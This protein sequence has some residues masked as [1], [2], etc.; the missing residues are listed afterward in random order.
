LTPLASMRVMAERKGIFERG[1]LCFEIDVHKVG[2]REAS[3]VQQVGE[4]LFVDAAFERLLVTVA[5]G[6]VFLKTLPCGSVETM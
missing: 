1:S 6:R 5:T 3:L 4:L 2:S